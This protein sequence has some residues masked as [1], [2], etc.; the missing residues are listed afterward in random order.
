M[1]TVYDIVPSS[2]D[3]TTSGKYISSYRA[4]LSISLLNA[5][6]ANGCNTNAFFRLTLRMLCAAAVIHVLD[7]I[8]STVQRKFRLISHAKRPNPAPGTKIGPFDGVY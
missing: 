8:A 6:A 7:S 3:G 2:K 4:S 1:P 5:S